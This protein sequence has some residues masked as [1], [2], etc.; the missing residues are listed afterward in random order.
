MPLA[1]TPQLTSKFCLEIY[2]LTHE[3]FCLSR[4]TSFLSTFRLSLA[5]FIVSSPCKNLIKNLLKTWGKISGWYFG[6]LWP[7]SA[8]SGLLSCHFWCLGKKT[9]ELSRYLCHNLVFR[10]KPM[11]YQM[12][13][14]ALILSGHGHIC[15]LHQESCSSFTCRLV[16]TASTSTHY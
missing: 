8:L 14:W 1:I 5:L 6:S 4:P 9:H 11:N 13:L 15:E 12:T 2:F 7:F 16:V 3:I 10:E